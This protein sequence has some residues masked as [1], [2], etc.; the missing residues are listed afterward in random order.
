[1]QNKTKQ[2][3]KDH[4]WIY[5]LV[6]LL[7]IAVAAVVAILFLLNNG[8]S[9]SN[10]GETIE[11]VQ[12]ISCTGKNI[13]YPY[14]EANETDEQSIALDFILNNDKINTASLTYQLTTEPGS[15]EKTTTNITIAINKSFAKDGLEH[16]ALNATF[17]S[18]SD[19]AQMILYAKAKDITSATA[20]YFLLENANGKHD[21][22]TIVKVLEE[23]G[24]SCKVNN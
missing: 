2:D 20:K 14:V 7:C 22:D 18:L 11:T 24:L 17:S 9:V 16:N 8:K 5:Y 10:Q 19:S 12:S 23:K 4:K 21:D 6:G 1:M 3:S 13:P 15:V